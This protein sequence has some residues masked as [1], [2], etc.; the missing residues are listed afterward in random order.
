M[1]RPLLCIIYD[2]VQGNS[3]FHLVACHRNFQERVG[4]RG[5]KSVNT[6]EHD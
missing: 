5:G 2:F 6:T 1:T 3:V 4:E